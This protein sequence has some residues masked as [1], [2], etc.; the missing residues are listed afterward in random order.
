MERV[1]WLLLGRDGAS[2]K[3]MMEE[4]QQSHRQSLPENHRK[5]VT[6]IQHLLHLLLHLYIQAC[7]SSVC[8]VL[9]PLPPLWHFASVLFLVVTNFIN[10]NSDWWRDPGDNEE[11]LGG[12]PVCVVSTHSCGCMASLQ[13]SSQPKAQQVKHTV[14]IC[15]ATCTQY[16]SDFISRHEPE[17]GKRASLANKARNTN[18]N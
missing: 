4:F 10:W 14:F 13:L 17:Q 3:N 18:S 2:V 9:H 7:L 1:F 6:I 16:I 8:L 15:L 11:M 5:L 12:K